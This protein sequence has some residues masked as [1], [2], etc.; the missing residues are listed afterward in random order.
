[1]CPNYKKRHRIE[2]VKPIS[3]LEPNIRYEFDLTFMNDDLADAYGVKILLGIIDVFSRKAMIY[4]EEN[5]L[6]KIY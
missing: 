1:M 6:L 3:L 5:K 2:P 4:K